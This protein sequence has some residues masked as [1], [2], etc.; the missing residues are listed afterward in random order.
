[1]IERRRSIRTFAL[2]CVAVTSVYVMGM[3]VWAYQMIGADWCVKGLG[4]A[5][6]A[7]GR[8]EYALKHCFQI[9]QQ[10]LQVLRE[11]SLIDGGVVALCL[12]VLMVIVV[13]G[14]RLSFKASTTGVET[15]ISPGEAVRAAQRTA[16][17]A[18]EEADDIAEGDVG[19]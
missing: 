5:K 8:P 11:G 17:A 6:Y 19:R 10:Q 2:V 12:A 16:D 13:A 9:Q 15:N 3:R 4:A 18:Q 7:T 1:M 14:G